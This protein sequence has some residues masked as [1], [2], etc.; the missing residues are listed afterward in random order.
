M[1][2]TLRQRGNVKTFL[3]NHTGVYRYRPLASKFM[4]GLAVLSLAGFFISVRDYFAE[5]ESSSI[6]TTKMYAMLLFGPYLSWSSFVVARRFKE[7]RIDE[8]G[9][10]IMPFGVHIESHEI[11]E[12][13]Q[14][15]NY[16]GAG[17]IELKL[18]S[19]YWIF[20]PVAW[21]WGRTVTISFNDRL[22]A[23]VGDSV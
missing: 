7:V 19:Y 4:L 10:S 2:D 20:Y 18:N 14:N 5:S 3:S 23:P 1:S 13:R 11:E 22:L 8:R 15:V 16:A 17:T 6:A 12:V 9:V 21:S